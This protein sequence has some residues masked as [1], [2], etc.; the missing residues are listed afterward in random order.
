[1]AKVLVP[2][3]PLQWSPALLLFVVNY[4][5]VTGICDTGPKKR[6]RASAPKSSVPL[7]I[8]PG[9]NLSGEASSSPA[10]AVHRRIDELLM[11]EIPFNPVNRNIDK[12]QGLFQLVINVIKAWLAQLSELRL[13][14]LSLDKMREP[15]LFGR[16]VKEVCKA[17]QVACQDDPKFQEFEHPSSQVKG[18]PQ[19]ISDYNR[20]VESLV[21]HNP[22]I[23]QLIELHDVQH[24]KQL[25]KRLPYG[26]RLMPRREMPAAVVNRLFGKGPQK[27]H[28]HR[29][30]AP[31]PPTDYSIDLFDNDNN[32]FVIPIVSLEHPYWR[33]P[34]F[35][36]LSAVS[37]MIRAEGNDTANFIMQCLDYAY[38]KTDEYSETMLQCLFDSGIAHLDVNIKER[39]EQAGQLL[40]PDYLEFV[41]NKLGN[42]DAYLVAVTPWRESSHA[43]FC[44]RCH[45]LGH[46]QDICPISGEDEGAF[47][48]SD[49]SCLVMLLHA[50]AE[51]HMS[52]SNTLHNAWNMIDAVALLETILSYQ[53]EAN[54]P[55]FMGGAKPV[56]HELNVRVHDIK[57]GQWAETRSNIE[58]LVALYNAHVQRF[59]NG[60][61]RHPRVAVTD[62]PCAFAKYPSADADLGA[63]PSG[64]SFDFKEKGRCGEN[65]KL[66][67][68]PAIPAAIA[69]DA[70][71]CDDEDSNSN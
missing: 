28:E 71:Q 49:A 23:Y 14:E 35:L 12:A 62:E 51:A 8:I 36:R 64:K 53:L 40:G 54:K 57:T 37:K 18:V 55:S 58:Y 27:E 31:A 10:E 44:E 67:E 21:E 2:R 56:D 60:N 39:M 16:Q 47:Q 24:M 30:A 48:L 66:W 13:D 41:K 1:M 7:P 33:N 65:S 25:F 61:G 4:A 32:L 59:Y 43:S 22:S 42:E 46:P 6:T 9:I 26:F 50:D 69:Q 70:M 5:V 20:L 68:L 34:I 38:G 29:W 17:V 11:N 45:I 63:M 19:L 15:N 3:L 52:G